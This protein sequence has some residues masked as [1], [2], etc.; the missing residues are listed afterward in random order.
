MKSSCLILYYYCITTY[1]S[2]DKGGNNGEELVDSAA[3]K[4][5]DNNRPR[6]SI[7]QKPLVV[8]GLVTRSE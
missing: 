3:S 6:D 2:T 5:A 8:P 1:C 4:N 7:S